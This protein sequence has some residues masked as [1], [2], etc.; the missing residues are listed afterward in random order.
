[1]ELRQY[2][3]I[4]QKWWWLIVVAVLIASGSSFFASQQA[5]P[6]YRTKTTLMVGQLIQSTDPSSS[7]L[8][9][10]QQLANT[11][12]QLAKREPVLKG[13]VERLGWDINWS[14]IAWQVTAQA[15]PQT[16]LV[17]IYVTDDDPLRAKVL[18]D[19]I[20]QQLIVLSPSGGYNV[21][22][23]Q[24]QFTQAQLDDL[25]TKISTSQEEVKRLKVELDAANSARLIQDLQ[26]Q[27]DIQETKISDWQQTYAELLA[28]IHGGEVNALNI[29]EG[30]T[31]PSTP[32]S[33]NT[34]MNV[35][36]AA[37]VGLVLAVGGIFVIEYLD[38][39]V[40][41]ADDI[42]KALDSPVLGKIGRISGGI[43][44]QSKLI[45]LHQPELPEAEGFRVVTVNVLPFIKNGGPK[46]I[47][48]ASPS[49]REGKSIIAANL[50]VVIA[51]TG[52]KVILVDA[53]MRQPKMHLLFGLPNVFGLRD[54]LVPPI[55]GGKQYLQS[56]PVDNLR[57]MTSGTSPN[58]PSMLLGSSNMKQLVD[59]LK[60]MADLILFDSP[61]SQAVADAGILAAI[62]DGVVIVADSGH[63]QIGD[64][65]RT[66]ADIQ[67]NHKNVKGFI[68]N[69]LKEGSRR[70]HNYYY[71]SDQG[72][73]RSEKKSGNH[74]NKQ[75]HLELAQEAELTS[76]LG[77]ETT[78]QIDVRK[79]ESQQ[80]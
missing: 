53:D 34:K 74:R 44:Y 37:V 7:E 18:A 50:A 3:G 27:V 75:E 60:T 5:T 72:S 45:T 2:F 62:V 14:A 13:A 28:S 33:P 78:K 76:L 22:Q 69:R 42:V 66:V 73:K 21:D 55:Y 35:L 8:Y 4:I 31:V 23:E 79:K 1:M 46:S 51:Q 64:I 38:D 40:K 63:T 57:I 49:P 20:A 80:K 67:Q 6:L 58:N 56:T 9:T 41:G 16:Q 39:T 19:A 36:L 65:R 68:I 54:A 61:A 25:K 32:F 26:N 10:A 15:L 11:Y 24:L 12:A 77:K 17:E 52:L 30:A 71:Y 48:M 70:Y 59:D 47:L 43:D 29:I